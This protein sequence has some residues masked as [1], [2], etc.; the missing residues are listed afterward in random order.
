MNTNSKI[1][2]CFSLRLKLP[3][4]HKNTLNKPFLFIHAL[5][6]STSE[7]HRQPQNAVFTKNY[8]E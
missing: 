5:N 6:I 2:N 8:E 1:I 4:K 3:Q 7:K